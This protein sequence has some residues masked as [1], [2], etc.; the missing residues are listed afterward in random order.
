[1]AMRRQVVIKAASQASPLYTKETYIRNK[2]CL[3][4]SLHCY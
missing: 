1:M 3:V 4:F 2:I